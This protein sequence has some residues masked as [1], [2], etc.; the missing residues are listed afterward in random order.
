MQACKKQKFSETM[1]FPLFIADCTLAV[2]FAKCPVDV[3]NTVHVTALAFSPPS[4]SI[5]SVAFATVPALSLPVKQ[6][7]RRAEVWTIG[8][9]SD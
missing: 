4:L 9:G 1:A 8:D 6:K 5:C 2:P 3:I 7:N